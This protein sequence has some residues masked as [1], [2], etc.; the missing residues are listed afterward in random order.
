MGFGLEGSCG[1]SLVIDG[2]DW[3]GD[4]PETL[5]YWLLGLHCLTNVT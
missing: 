3:G 2:R 5:T 1:G 4:N